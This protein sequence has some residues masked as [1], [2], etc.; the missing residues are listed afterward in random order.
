MFDFD[1]FEV[2]NYKSLSP[3]SR[4]DLNSN[5][6]LFIGKNNTGKSSCLDI[7]GAV[8]DDRILTDYKKSITLA[9]KLTKPRFDLWYK[10]MRMHIARLNENFDKYLYIDTSC[11][12]AGFTYRRTYSVSA[13]QPEVEIHKNYRHSWNS[14][15][16]KYNNVNPFSNYYWCRLDADRDIKQERA[17]DFSSL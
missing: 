3:T 9:L 12:E 4:I 6:S 10:Q 7:I 8:Y 1:Y 14:L 15:S 16:E 5:I 2:G 11:R 13:N 17:F